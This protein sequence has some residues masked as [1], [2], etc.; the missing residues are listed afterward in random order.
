[1]NNDID[2]IKKLLKTDKLV[3]GTE[4]TL[5]RLK[6]TKLENVYIAKNCPADVKA[7]ITHYTELAG[8]KLIL[9]DIPNDELGDLCKK[10]FSISVIGVL[11]E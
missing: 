5:K 10:S 9:L 1:M 3:I 11:K 8:V 7:D 4:E 6:T 2:E